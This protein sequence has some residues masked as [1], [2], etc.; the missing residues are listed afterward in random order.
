MILN[1]LDRA[2]AGIREAYRIAQESFVKGGVN[3]VMLATDGDTQRT[4]QRR[5][6]GEP[7][8]SAVIP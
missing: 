1:A 5:R 8:P 3:R 7:P 4:G 6:A 2:A